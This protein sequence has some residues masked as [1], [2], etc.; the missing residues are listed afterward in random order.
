MNKKILVLGIVFVFVAS[1]FVGCTKEHVKKGEKRIVG[2][3]ILKTQTNTYNSTDDD[4]YTYSVSI[5]ETIDYTSASTYIG[6]ENFD[7]STLKDY[8]K[9]SYT[10]T[11]G[12][13]TNSSEHDTTISYTYSFELTFNEDGTCFIAEEKKDK[14]TGA[15]E[16]ASLTGRWDW[17]DDGNLEKVGIYV[18]GDY[19][20][21]NITTY[22]NL[23]IE[24]LDKNELII[25]FEKSFE[26]EGTYT[27]INYDWCY[28]EDYNYIY[29][30]RTSES[31]QSLTNSG[32]QTF[33]KKDE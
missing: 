33:E 4:S 11:S 23:Y 9:S 25:S 8:Y 15:I 20:D 19:Y 32:S 17:I 14:G 16:N 26:S 22:Y 28:D 31:K 21:E 12:G 27:S 29:Y 30:D 7:G 1:I 24:T 5:C 10:M 3:W 18:Y 13:T 2:T 6:T